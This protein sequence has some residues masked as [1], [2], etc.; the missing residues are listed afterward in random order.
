MVIIR[1]KGLVK[2]YSSNN[3]TYRVIDGVDLEINDGDYLA[4]TGASGSGKSTLLYLL[5]GLET[6]TRGEVEILGKNIK[7]LKDREMAKLRR[8][9]ISY[10]YQFFNLIPNLT[11]YENIT[12]PKKID[13]KFTLSEKEYLNELVEAAGIGGI[14]K[15]RPAE[16][17]GGEQQRAA[18][19]R[20]VFT[21]PKVILAD[22]PTGN[23]DS[24]AGAKVLELIGEINSRYNTA[25]VMVTHSKEHAALAKKTITLKDGKITE[26]NA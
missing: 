26:D 6:P 13:K 15:K 19:V 2:E 3:I 12:L 18:F 24:K 22:E 1:A 16:V 11:V 14:L 8:R 5:G 23:L 25:V 20:A 9:D 17:S 10:V 4:V 7:E 21:R